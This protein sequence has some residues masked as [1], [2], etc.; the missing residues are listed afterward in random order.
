MNSPKN[1]ATRRCNCGWLQSILKP[2]RSGKS[3]KAQESRLNNATIA[4]V[5][6]YRQG[7]RFRLEDPNENVHEFK[8][9]SFF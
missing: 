8:K 5:R 6:L 4:Q 2:M 1:E 9:S 7:R 3:G